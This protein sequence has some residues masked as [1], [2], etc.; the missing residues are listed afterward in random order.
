MDF[1]P[2]AQ[3]C[4]PDVHPDTLQRIVH[5]ESSYNPYT[6]GV[7]GAHLDRQ[8]RNRAEAIATAD[9]LEH[10]GY[11]YSAG[12]AQ[13]NKTNFAKY[14]LSR[15]TAFDACT[16]L[17]AG[18]EIL[19][20]C[21]KRA[22]KSYRDEQVA[23]RA[24]F[25]CYYSGNFFTGFKQGYVLKIVSANSGVKSSLAMSGVNGI[26]TRSSMPVLI[27]GKVRK[28]SREDTAK[29]AMNTRSDPTEFAQ[30]PD[31]SAFLF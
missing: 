15:E 12:L 24:A 10:N 2:M 1:A 5:V 7:V 4:A 18:G 28:N 20:E 23:L 19:K 11:N 16:N 31:Q 3:Q 29:P 8:P 13:V 22:S 14:G 17:R 9:W 6:I 27:A 25:S 30:D 21:F 26:P